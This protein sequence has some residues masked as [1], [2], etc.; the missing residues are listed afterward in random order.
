MFLKNPHIRFGKLSTL[1]GKYDKVIVR[2]D[3]GCKVFHYYVYSKNN[4]S[5]NDYY[6]FC[7]GTKVVI[8]EKNLSVDYLLLSDLLK[9][10]PVIKIRNE[11]IFYWVE[12]NYIVKAVGN[13]NKVSFL[14]EETIT[15]KLNGRELF[16]INPNDFIVDTNII[17]RNY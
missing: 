7:D 6:G 4:M 1:F 14:L 15:S 11:P 17:S 10:H 9:V 12:N 3:I 13:P 16:Y 5:K 8:S 2:V